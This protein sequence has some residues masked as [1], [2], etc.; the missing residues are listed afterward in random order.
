M[1]C[2]YC[3]RTFGRGE[4]GVQRTVKSEQFVSYLINHC[5]KK[6]APAGNGEIVIHHCI[7]HAHGD[8]S[9]CPGYKGLHKEYVSWKAAQL[10]EAKEKTATRSIQASILAHSA[11]GRS[12]H[13]RDP[14]LNLIGLD[15][16]QHFPRIDSTAV[17]MECDEAPIGGTTTGL[18]LDEAPMEVLYDDITHEQAVVEEVGLDTDA[19]DALQEPGLYGVYAVKGRGS[20]E[21]GKWDAKVKWKGNLHHCGRFQ[22]SEH[23]AAAYNNKLLDLS[24]MLGRPFSRVSSVLPLRPCNLKA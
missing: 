4:K 11:Q 17:R 19:V 15:G 23:A 5:G 20:L 8:Y 16:G 12:S 14:D 13:V 24:V 2:S 9:H 21:S 10:K 7:L 3:S 18:E 22:T 1:K 6:V